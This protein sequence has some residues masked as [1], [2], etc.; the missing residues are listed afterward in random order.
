MTALW[1]Q[2]KTKTESRRLGQNECGNIILGLGPALAIRIHILVVVSHME[3]IISRGVEDHHLDATYSGSYLS[4]ELIEA[5]KLDG[6]P[7]DLTYIHGWIPGRLTACDITM[8][9]NFWNE[10]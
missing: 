10:C 7:D 4:F 8:D 1:G 3:A 2:M 6:R 5:W 9:F